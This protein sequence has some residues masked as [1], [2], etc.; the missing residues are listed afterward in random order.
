MTYVPIH[1]GRIWSLTNDQEIALKKVWGI[2][3]KHC[4][5]PINIS[6]ESIEKGDQLVASITDVRLIGDPELIGS[7]SKETST[8]GSHSSTLTHTSIS[9]N[10]RSVYY[11]LETGGC[12]NDDDDIFSLYQLEGY[13][14]LKKYAPEILHKSLW[15][16]GRNDNTDNYLLRFL[17]I[18]KFNYKSSLSWIA[19]ILDWRHAKYNVEDILF[20]GDAHIFFELKSPNLVDVFRRNEMYVRGVARSGSPLIIFRGAKHKRGRCTDA[21]F[22]KVILLCIEWARLGFLEYKQGVDQ[23]HVIIDLTGFTM[24]HADFHGVKFGIRAFQKY[25]PDS[26]ERLQIHNAPRVFSAMWKILEHWMKPHLRE[27]I[28]FTKSIGEL[29]KYIDPKYIPAD[30]GG[31]E[32][33]PP[34][35]IEPTFF[36]CQ[37]KTPDEAFYSLTKERDELTVKF[38]ESTIKWIEATT[39][40]E[41]KMHLINKIEISRARAINY[42]NL[43]PYLRTRGIPDR[44]GEVAIISY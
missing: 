24:K 34:A 5:Y 11:V 40:E 26:L 28:S 9:S 10:V 13:S 27:R 38:I 16:L 8:M 44:N 4:G 7:R 6:I 37:R 43:D 33:H 29:T 21:Q 17:R 12:D 30:I 20:K 22:E 42:I 23:F 1:Q 19:H 41:S 15:A 18:S 25:F 31:A 35:Y 14:M 39:S 2:L 3:L 36:N 32:Q